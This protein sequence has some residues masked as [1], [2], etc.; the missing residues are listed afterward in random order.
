MEQVAAAL[1][2]RPRLSDAA[3]PGALAPAR[4][5]P[6]TPA[7]FQTV[8]QLA[9]TIWRAHYASIVGIAQIDYML[10]GRF[11]PANLR[12]YLDAPDRWMDLLRLG[13]EAIGYCSYA[14]TAPPGAMQPGAM[15]L[16]QLYLLQGFRGRGLGALMLSHVESRARE[17]GL[18]LLTLQVNKRNHAAIELYRRSGFEVHEAA[19][20]DIG[21]GY[22]MDDY[23]MRKTLPAV[24]SGTR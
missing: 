5:E 8:A 19:V 20:F 24:A 16:E 3:A 18:Q 14:R 10:A 15:K 23:V 2:D 13:D 7:D 4:L 22:L 1:P 12:T 9:A 6:L 17:Q 21:G 11:T